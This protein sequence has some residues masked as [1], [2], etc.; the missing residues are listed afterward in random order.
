M[1]QIYSQIVHVRFRWGGEGFIQRSKIKSRIK[2]LVKTLHGKRATHRIT[3]EILEPLDKIR[4]RL[5]EL[6]PSEM[7]HYHSIKILQPM[8]KLRVL[9]LD[10]TPASM[11][12]MSGA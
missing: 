3:L 10:Q 7:A 11:N 1:K 4:E 9:P 2:V 12:I 5:Y 8:G 6:E